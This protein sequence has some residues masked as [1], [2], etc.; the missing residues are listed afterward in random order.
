MG[1]LHDKYF[2]CIFDF[3]LTKFTCS[4]SPKAS[5][6]APGHKYTPK[7]DF[8]PMDCTDIIIGMARETNYRIGDY[9]T[10]D[11]STP[12]KDEYWGGRDSLTAAFGYERDGVTTILFRRKLA[13]AEPTDHEIR[14]GNMQVIWARG[15][16]PGKYM[17]QPASGIEKAKAS[18]KDFYKVDELKYHGH[19]MQRGAVTMN[20][21]GEASSQ[22]ATFIRKLLGGRTRHDKI[23]FTFL[24]ILK[25]LFL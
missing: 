2:G 14:D 25:L 3:A 10:R 20:F 12:R 22:L 24:N 18:V 21:F 9:Y 23:V 17:H 1:I 19:G 11:R 4:L 16:E 8:N 5:L 7:H 15:Q 6:P 13:A